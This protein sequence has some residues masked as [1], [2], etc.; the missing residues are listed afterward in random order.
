MN[1]FVQY[2]NT[3]NFYR[4]LYDTNGFGCRTW[5]TKVALQLKLDGY[6]D[7]DIVELI[8]TEADELRSE[9]KSKRRKIR[10]KYKTVQ[11]QIYEV[12]DE[13]SKF[14]TYDNGTKMATVID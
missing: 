14:F 2:C 3:H 1:E 7:G 4:Y 8:H 9:K 5:I 13:A 6:M 11:A 10:G 12:P